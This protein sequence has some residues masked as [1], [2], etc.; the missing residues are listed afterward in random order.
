M[1]LRSKAV[2]KPQ[3]GELG[4]GHCHHTGGLQGRR[5]RGVMRLSDGG[6]DPQEVSHQ[7]LGY[8]PGGGPVEGDIWN[9]QLPAIVLHPV[10]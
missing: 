9:H 4:E 3:P 5:N 8:W 2:G 1:A 10:T 7:L 6:D